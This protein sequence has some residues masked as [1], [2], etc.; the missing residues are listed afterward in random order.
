MASPGA[1]CDDKLNGSCFARND[2]E[3]KER[4]NKYKSRD[5]FPDIE[6]ALLNSA[7]ICDYVAAT[8]MIFPFYPDKKRLKPASYALALAGQCIYW[9]A[10]GKEKEFTIGSGNTF[11]LQSDSI[12][13][14]TLEPMFR[15]PDYIALRFNLKITL[16]YRGLL[17]GTGPLVDP[18]FQGKLHLPLHNLTTND[19]VIK[20]GEALVWVEFTKLSDNKIWANEQEEERDRIGRYIPFPKRKKYLKLRDYLTK[21]APNRPIRSSIPDAIA[22]A[23]QAATEAEEETKRWGKILSWGALAAFVALISLV[24][25]IYSLNASTH[26]LIGDSV[27]YVSSAQGEV[28]ASQE[29]RFGAEGKIEALQQEIDG[30]LRRIEQLELETAPT[31]EV[32]ESSSTRPQTR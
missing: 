3:A 10:E 18:G 22:S 28:R 16:V 5:P 21:A 11:T 19:Y 31:D 27:D 6:S 24:V 13:F 4:Y 29:Q 7:D 25:S 12:A 8:G 9:D 1:P 20:G 32:M 17:V 23:E 14:L 30:L 2:D 15:L 26:N